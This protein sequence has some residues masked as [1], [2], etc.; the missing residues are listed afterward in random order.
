MS[1]D[2]FRLYV[3]YCLGNTAALT[4]IWMQRVGVIWLAWELSESTFW[5]GMIAASQL[6]PS[7]L[8]GP[9]FGAYVDRVDIA[10]AMM[11]V[12]LILAGLTAALSLVALVGFATIGVLL[13]FEVLIGITVSAHQPL[14]MALVPALVGQPDMPRAIALDSLVFNLTRIVG[15]AVG[16]A[17]VVW[18][19]IPPVLLIGALGNII[20][21]SV[22]WSL[23]DHVMHKPRA[24]RQFLSDLREGWRVVIHTTEVKTAFLLTAIFAFG[25]RAE[26]E[27]F[28][29]LAATA[30]DRDAAGGGMLLSMTGVGAISAAGILAVRRGLPERLADRAALVGFIALW[31][32]AQT[33]SW[34]VGLV[35]ATIIGFATSVVGVA[36]QAKVQLSIP[37]GFHG[38]I[39]GIWVMVGIGSMAVGTMTYGIV[40]ERIGLRATCQSFAVAGMLGISAMIIWRWRGGS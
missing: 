24:T 28:P 26:I 5:T 7:I 11:R 9:L 13:V 12:Q 40:S 37:D 22:I 39:M 19:G 18:A 38:R 20:L 33:E 34:G 31:G 32:L 10:R 21:F 35:F 4:C 16:G 3:R 25:A 27:L 8:C 36:N 2:R 29:I 14:R 30:F 15:P 1:Q 6:V 23:K 17:G